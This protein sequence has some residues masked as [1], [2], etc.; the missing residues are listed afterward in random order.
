[1]HWWG[2]Y[3]FCTSFAFV[4]IFIMLGK[5][6]IKVTKCLIIM[7][8]M[9]AARFSLLWVTSSGSSLTFK[10]GHVFG[11]YYMYIFM[12]VYMYIHM[13]VCL[14]LC[15]HMQMDFFFHTIRNSAAHLVKQELLFTGSES[16]KRL[17][18]R[19]IIRKVN[20]FWFV[21]RSLHCSCRLSDFS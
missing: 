8:F 7:L 14:C 17:A 11:M 12:K 19:D 20:S 1:M 21:C 5:E 3:E 9:F 16:G 15:I 13:P 18:I 4:F 6:K 10:F 2:I